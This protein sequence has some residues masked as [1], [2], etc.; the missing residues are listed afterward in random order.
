[1]PKELQVHIA[2]SHQ[3]ADEWDFRQNLEMSSQQRIEAVR[4]LQLQHFGR[5]CPDIR[6]SRFVQKVKRK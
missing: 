5:F 2:K 6:E 1:M 4:K 3:E